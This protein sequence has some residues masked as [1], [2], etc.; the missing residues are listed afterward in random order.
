MDIT[1]KCRQAGPLTNVNI[2]CC[3]TSVVGTL[4]KDSCLTCIMKSLYSTVKECNKLSSKTISAFTH[5]PWTASSHS[6]GSACSQA[7]CS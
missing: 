3:N 6:P 5:S 4:E 7:E 2:Q 1:V